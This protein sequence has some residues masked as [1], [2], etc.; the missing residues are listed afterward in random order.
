MPRGGRV[1]ESIWVNVLSAGVCAAL[2]LLGTW[3]AARLPNRALWKLSDPARLTVCVAESAAVDTGK[4]IRKAT[5][6]GQTRALAVIAPSLTRAYGR[7]DTRHIQ[8][9]EEP[10]GARAEGDLV[11]LGGTKNNVR[12][13]DVIAALVEQGYEVPTMDGS[14]IRWPGSEARPA[15]EARTEGGVVSKDYGLIIRAPNPFGSSSTVIVLAGAST[16]GA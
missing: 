6:I 7:I 1:L 16:Y 14:S 3:L 11:C 9:S 13:R 5:G 2:G 12:T 15:Y 4:Y 10:L 8:L